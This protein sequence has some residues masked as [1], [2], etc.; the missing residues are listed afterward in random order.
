MT[1]IPGTPQHRRLQLLHVA[2]ATWVLLVSATVVIDHVALSNLADESKDRTPAMRIAVLE[3]RLDDLAQQLDQHRQRPTA[4]PQTRYESERRALDQ[5]IAAV[6]AA[7]GEH[8]TTDALQ[9]LLAR[10][11]RIEARLATARPT[12]SASVRPRAPTPVKPRPVEP[13]FRVIGVDL[14][15][16][17]RFVAIL[18]TNTAALEQVR[19]LRP[20]E[21]EAGWR[22]EAIEGGTAVFRHGDETRRLIV[23]ER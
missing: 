10:L 17:E 21:A 7:L 12:P 23:P 19:L 18:P 22:L 20:G 16:G 15:A 4:L 3:G 5:R 6:E 8:P 11:E 13:A 2:A 9:S 1:A 14:R